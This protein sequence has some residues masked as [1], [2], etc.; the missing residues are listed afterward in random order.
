MVGVG[1]PCSDQREPWPEGDY[2]SRSDRYPRSGPGWQALS[3]P[4]AELD[5]RREVVGVLNGADF[6]VGSFAVLVKADA[7]NPDLA[8]ADHGSLGVDEEGVVLLFEDGVVDLRGDDAVVVF[9]E[10]LAIFDGEG[11][12][13]GVDLD[14][15]VDERGD[16]GWV[17]IGDGALQVG[18]DLVD[19]D[20][21][22]DGLVDGFVELRGA[23]LGVA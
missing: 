11:M 10:G 6:D 12:F 13:A 22:A 16:T 8:F 20:V 2:P 23:G 3:F 7:G 1:I 5:R 21:V 9:D 15:V 4:K 19:L 18:E 17:V 14:R